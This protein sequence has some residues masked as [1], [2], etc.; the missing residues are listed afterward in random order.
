MKKIFITLAYVRFFE[1]FDSRF[2]G[3]RRYGYRRTD[4]IMS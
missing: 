4:E 1:H 3:V 2:N